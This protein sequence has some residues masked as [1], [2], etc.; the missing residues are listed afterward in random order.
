VTRHR[1]YQVSILPIPTLY[2][3]PDCFVN[4]TFKSP[5]YPCSDVPHLS[6]TQPTLGNMPRRPRERD[7]P[8]TRVLHILSAMK[9]RGMSVTSF[10]EAYFASADHRIKSRVGWFFKHQGLI[11]VFQAMIRSSKYAANRRATAT[12]T[13]E[14]ADTIKHDILRLVLRIFQHEMQ[15]V[16]KDPRSRVNP[17]KI[18]PIGCA[19]FSFTEIQTVFE[20]KSP[21][22]WKAIRILAGTTQLLDSEDGWDDIDKGT[23][24]ETETDDEHDSAPSGAYGLDRNNT[25]NL[26]DEESDDTAYLRDFGDFGPDKDPI[27]AEDVDVDRRNWVFESDLQEAFLGD[28]HPFRQRRLGRDRA[29]MAACS[30]SILLYSR[31][32]WNNYMQAMLGI[33]ANAVHIPKRAVSTLNRCGFLV[34]YDTTRRG[35]RAVAKHDREILRAKIRDG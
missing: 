33:W 7:T 35:L 12:A 28:H 22:L 17:D 16:A 29:L 5:I 18:T 31:S 1:K 25:Q 2:S 8:D 23:E 4:L 27:A 30:M 11:R 6:L 32:R 10:M 24:T 20:E 34:S 26:L 19:E 14:I 15:A 9:S 13:A 21:T 3:Y